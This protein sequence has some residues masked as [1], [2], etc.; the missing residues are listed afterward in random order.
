MFKKNHGNDSIRIMENIGIKWLITKK[1]SE[2]DDIVDSF[3]QKSLNVRKNIVREKDPEKCIIELIRDTYTCNILLRYIGLMMLLSSDNH[4]ENIDNKL[5]KY[6]QSYYSNKKFIKKIMQLFDHYVDIFEKNKMNEDYCKFLDKIICKGDVSHD[7]SDV[8]KTIRMIENRIFN[9][10]NINSVVKIATRHLN[11][12]PTNFEMKQDKV[13]IPLN[14]K[15]YCDLMNLVD[16]MD[17]RH[18]IE[19]QYMSKTNNVL[20]D[21]SNLV[22]LRKELA[23]QAGYSTFFKYVN[24]GKFD[25]S[26]TIKNLITELNH[27]IN[28]KARNEINKIHQYFTKT[29]NA[30]KKNNKQHETSSTMNKISICDVI[31]YNNMY[32]NNTTF[33]VN[34]VLNTIFNIIGNYFSIKFEKSKDYD[35]ATLQSWRPNIDVLNVIDA[36]NGK[37]MG[38]LFLDVWYDEN[39]NVNSP[40]SIRMS[41]KMQI[42]YPFTSSSSHTIAESILIANYANNKLLTYSDIVLLFREFGYILSGTCYDSRVGL[43]N[44]DEEFSNYLPLLMEYIAWDRDT[45]KSMLKNKS[46]SKNKS[47]INNTDSSLIDLIEMERSIDLCFNLKIKCVNAKFDHLI[48]NSEP[49]MDL[50]INTSKNNGNVCDDILNTYKDVYKEIMDPL[51]DIMDVD[52]AHIDPLTIIQEINNSQSMLYANLMNEIFAY[53][54][55]W[56]IKHNKSRDFRSCVLSDGTT[57]YRDLVRMFLKKMDPSTNCFS[58]Y[59]KNVIKVDECTEDNV[60][61]D[62]ITEDINYFDDNLSDHEPDKEEIIQ[63]NRSR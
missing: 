41:D 26:D 42:I 56:I 8:K 29:F 35:F 32:K 38:R 44:Y 51:S 54:S 47:M 46:L 36:L 17:I 50:L 62:I 28:T 53:A 1:V 3:V 30:A 16:D 23:S 34:D 49:L 37:I 31:K 20:Q 21:F 2:I 19:K 60:D 63:I 33:K 12:V 25:N 48:H 13:I 39:K 61:N 52:I 4:W 15:N 55:Y 24:R 57:N 43:V 45:I 58:L 5:M 18:Q 22:L 27:K 11:K 59:V 10:L 9:L 14:Q 40:I 7:N 6:I